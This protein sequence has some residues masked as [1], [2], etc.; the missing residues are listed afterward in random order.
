MAFP[1]LTIYVSYV[2][3]SLISRREKRFRFFF[4]LVGGTKQ[5]LFG[6]RIAQKS[7]EE[8][9]GISMWTYSPQSIF[10]SQCMR[11]GISNF[12]WLVSQDLHS[13]I[14]C[15]YENNYCAVVD[16]TLCNSCLKSVLFMFCYISV[17]NFFPL[18]VEEE[19]TPKDRRRK[20]K[21]LIIN[22]KMYL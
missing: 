3:L 7:V 22:M 2:H 20:G 16:N 14:Q 9:T 10:S 21:Y 19:C 4:V 15:W 17:L 11:D 13:H 8:K 12:I 18:P 5:V 1:I 6:N